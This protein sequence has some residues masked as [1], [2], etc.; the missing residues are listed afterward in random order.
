MEALTG[1]CLQP[2]TLPGLTGHRLVLEDKGF[3]TADLCSSV[4]S[5]F[6]K[7]NVTYRS[8][9]FPLQSHRNY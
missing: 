3:L 8:Q 6:E 1:L 4:H 7:P 9:R 2:H 5:T